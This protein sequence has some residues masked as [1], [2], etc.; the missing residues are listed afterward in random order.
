MQKQRHSRRGVLLLVVLSMLTLFLLLGVTFIVLAS[1]A[2]TVS[3]AYLQMANEQ[4][5]D[6][7]MRPLIR[8]AAL[9]VMRGTLTDSVL[10]YHDLL[11]DRYGDGAAEFSITGAQSRANNQLLQLTLDSTVQLSQTGCVL[12]FVDG[13]A[14]VK[15]CGARIIE[16]NGGNSLYIRW[17]PRLQSNELNLLRSTKVK[18]N[19]RDYGGE[20]VGDQEAQEPNWSLVTSSP[21]GINEDYDAVD[22]Q[23][24]ALAEVGQSVASY[25]RPETINQAVEQ[26]RQNVMPNSSTDAAE[27]AIYALLQQDPNNFSGRYPNDSNLPGYQLK[28][29]KQLRRAS[30]RPFAMDHSFFDAREDFTGKTWANATQFFNVL[31]GS[32]FDVD[33][34][35]DGQL[36]SVWLDFGQEPFRLSDGRFIKPLAAIRCIDL[37][38]RVN[39]NAHGSLAHMLGSSPGTAFDSQPVGLGYGPAD[40]HL[41]AV[42]SDPE[43]SDIYLGRNQSNEKGDEIYR[44]LAARNGRY[45]GGVRSSDNPAL[46]GSSDQDDT[47]T[48]MELINSGATLQ[49]TDYWSRYSIGLEHGHPRLYPWLNY[50]DTANSPYELN[51]LNPG[52][53]SPFVPMNGAT[54]DDQPFAPTELESILRRRDPDNASLL[55][56]RLLGTFLQDLSKLNLITTESWDTPAIIGDIPPDTDL[57]GSKNLEIRRGLKLNLNRPFGDRLDN[58]NDSIVDE[59]DETDLSRPTNERDPY[60]GNLTRGQTISNQPGSNVA[61]LRARQIMAQNLYY[62]LSFLNDSADA[63]KPSDRELAQ[64]AVNVVDYIDSDAIMTPFEYADDLNPAKNVVWG[65]ESPDLIVT[66]TLAFHDRAIADTEDDNQSGDEDDDPDTPGTKTTAVSPDIPDTDFDQ[67]RVPQGSLFIELHAV[68]DRNADRLPRELYNGSSGSW[69][70]DLAR[71]PAGGTDPVWRLSFADLRNNGSTANDPFRAI[72]EDETVTLSPS[73]YNEGFSLPGG[74]NTDR[75]AYFTNSIPLPTYPINGVNH[76]KPNRFNTFRT[77]G[78]VALRCGEFLVAGSREETYLGSKSDDFGKRS[79]QKIQVKNAGIEITKLDGEDFPY[80]YPESH[81][82]ILQSTRSALW[83][84]IG[85]NISEPLGYEYYATPPLAQPNPG[86]ATPAYGPLSADTDAEYPD[87][88]GDTSDGSPLRAAD[89][90]AQGTHLNAST[91]F[92]ERLADPTRPFEP[93]AHS[94][95][96]N[97]Y[98]VVDFM[99]IDLTVFNGETS[100]PDPS[101]SDDID[102]HVQTRQRGFDAWINQKQDDKEIFS[103]GAALNDPANAVFSKNPWR[104]CSPWEKDNDTW[105]VRPPQ[106]KESTA[107]SSSANF[108][109]DIGVSFDDTVPTHTLGWCNLSQGDRQSDGYPEKPFPWIVWKDGP[110]ANPYELLMVP[111]TSVSRL[112]TDYRDVGSLTD[113]GADY[114]DANDIEKPFGVDTDQ[115]FGATRPGHHLLPLTSITDR[116]LDKDNPATLVSDSLSR[117]FGYVRTPSPFVGVREELT[118]DNLPTLFRPPFNQTET[119]REPGRVNVNTISDARVWRAVLGDTSSNGVL[120]PSWSDIQNNLLASTPA[121]TASGRHRGTETNRSTTLLTDKAVGEP[122][123]STPDNSDS[124]FDPE[125]SS[126]FRFAQM[127]RASANTTERSEVY[128]IWVTVGLFEVEAVSQGQ[129]N[130]NVDS[131]GNVTNPAIEAYPSGY[132]ISQ[133]YGSSSGD[134]KRYRGFYI[135]DRSRPICYDPGVDHNVDEGIL[136]ER[137]IE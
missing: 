59:P 61:G 86:F 131:N 118:G 109:Y 95:N 41:G 97:P 6:L 10:K 24:I 80:T 22:L 79:N 130:A 60:T 48:A 135:F 137:F 5:S 111:R 96:W 105:Q 106:W 1:R 133:E 115:P 52:N 13:P 126:W 100:A 128:A 116:P 91:V 117:L 68:R 136:I 62:L 34:D 124:Q 101:V 107:G 104:P 11:G 94:E 76:R 82:V 81:G 42:L 31:R 54:L 23:N 63:N 129:I 38:G 112:L 84:E 16:A 102:W 66:E 65:C 35:G 4:Q 127:I 98:I 70:L 57:G 73:D 53:V 134:M 20:G 114:K 90:L 30:L 29:V 110:L 58:D 37:G 21:N 93:D 125:K 108:K 77:P 78:P 17:P 46:P 39:V 18:I 9:Q 40:V 27:K 33:A 67:I 44:R 26:Y 8:E 25:H 123:F 43:I 74:F 103:L 3:K 87:H 89:L 45:G 122:L 12:Y 7:A 121:R 49:P 50:N 120:K 15:G 99:P 32:T 56:Q 119:Y 71:V 92:V 64:W 75:Y 83:Q 55:P 14:S 72:H 51:L 19:R 69:S 2:R 47:D 113:V 88:P 36:D 85:L 28:V 132:K